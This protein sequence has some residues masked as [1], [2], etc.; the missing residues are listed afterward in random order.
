MY[1]CNGIL[2]NHESPLRGET[3]V[4]RKI[5]RAV[6]AISQGTQ[7]QLYLGN[8][9]AKRDWG[10]ARDYARGMWMML[11]QPEP[12]DFVL[13][14]GESHTVREF[15]ERAFQCVD[16]KIVWRGHGIDEAGVDAKSGEVLVRIDPRYFR[17][18]EV[19]T[20]CG[21]ASKAR[22]RLGWRPETAFTDLVREM[23]EEDLRIVR[24]AKSFRHE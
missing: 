24:S 23:M 9:D 13:A 6:A 2:F 1:A 19:D 5:T 16:R 8:L 22:Q 15:V 20:L 11:Q 14:T 18:T 21:D 12:D 3:F 4:T 10:H 17:P 7:A